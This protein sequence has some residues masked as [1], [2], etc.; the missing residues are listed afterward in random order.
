MFWSQFSSTSDWIEAKDW[1]FW[2]AWGLGGL[3]AGWTRKEEGEV[4]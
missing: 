4:D 2:G 1:K 3:G